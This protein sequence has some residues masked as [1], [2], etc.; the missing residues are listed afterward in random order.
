VAVPD[1]PDQA[2]L[3]RDQRLVFAVAR[4]CKAWPKL[5]TINL[6]RAIELKQT[7]HV[8]VE[9][10]AAAVQRRSRAEWRPSLPSLQRTVAAAPL[11]VDSTMG[12]FLRSLIILQ[13]RP[14]SVHRSA[15]TA[16]FKLSTRSKTSSQFTPLSTYKQAK[17]FPP[18]HSTLLLD[19]LRAVPI[20]L[21]AGVP[22]E[23][24]AEVVAS[25]LG[26]VGSRS[27]LAV[28]HEAAELPAL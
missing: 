12:G 10:P 18:I 17:G 27:Q 7:S 16:R 1:A 13:Q 25:W 19:L 4:R 6:R 5:G 8:E 24:A 15:K 26:L 20:G 21:L 9:R 3:T 28:C 22:L 2:K 11:A 23:V 14:C